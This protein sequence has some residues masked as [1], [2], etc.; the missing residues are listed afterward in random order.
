MHK[1]L[2]RCCFFNNGKSGYKDATG[3]TIIAPQF[4]LAGRFSEG[5]ANGKTSIRGSQW[6]FRIQR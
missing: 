6:L 2:H 5:L 1:W 4:G 3:K